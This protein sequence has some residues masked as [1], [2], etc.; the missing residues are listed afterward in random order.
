MII[1]NFEAFSAAVNW[2]FARSLTK[3]S[4]MLVVRKKSQENLSMHKFAVSVTLAMTCFGLYTPPSYAKAPLCSKVLASLETKAIESFKAN[5][6]SKKTSQ[7]FIQSTA[8]EMKSTTGNRAELKF[9]APLMDLNSI[10]GQFEMRLEKWIPGFKLISR[11]TQ[12]PGYKNVTYTKYLTKLKIAYKGQELTT[13]IRLRK[14][15]LIEENSVVDKN[16]F[17]PIESMKDPNGK[18]FSWLEFKIEH[19]DFENAVLKPRIKFHD[20]FS[21]L[22]SNNPSKF[23]KDFKKIVQKT[24]DLNPESKE[25]V[26]NMLEAIR[27]TLLEKLSLSMISE[28]IYYRTSYVVNLQSNQN[29]RVNIQLTIDADI[30]QYSSV[31]GKEVQTYDPYS[32]LSV[33]EVKIPVQ[34]SAL[35]KADLQEVQGLS[36]IQLMLSELQQVQSKDYEMNKGKFSRAVRVLLQEKQRGQNEL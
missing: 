35:S 27:L 31:L 15:G 21:D 29:S 17:H 32:N 5:R 1:S 24:K 3:E 8:N 22:M 14:Y 12:T 9:T 10:L 33:I 16:I 11:D 26:E 6:V 34:Y 7:A 28:T 2:H 19:P 36:E 20:R 30:H 13:K 18:E 23:L 4:C 25:T